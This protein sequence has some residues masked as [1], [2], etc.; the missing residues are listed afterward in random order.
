MAGSLR[1]LGGLAKF[2]KLKIG[3]ADYAAA[4]IEV[5]EKHVA[6]AEGIRRDPRP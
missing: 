5:I 6:E 3:R 1:D 2:H 4:K